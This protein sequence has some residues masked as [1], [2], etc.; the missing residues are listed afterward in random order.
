MY[1]GSTRKLLINIAILCAECGLA[2]AQTPLPSA[3]TTTTSGLAN[4]NHIIVLLQENRSFDSYFGELRQYWK[5]NGYPDQSFDG[6]PQFNPTS[7][8][9]PLYKAPP[10]NKGCDP[11]F[12]PPKDCTID[13]AS[14]K[15]ES[16]ELNT[17]CTENTSPSWNESHFDW[18]LSDP[19]GLNAAKENG[20][21][22]TAAHDA[23]A[24]RP[25]YN[26]VA[27]RRAMGY[28]T[29]KDLNFYYFMAS[30]FATS[31]RWFSPVMTRTH[32]NRE[33]FY[34]ATSQGDV[35]PIG[36]D[37][38]D[39]QLLTAKTILQDLQNAGVSWKIYVNPKNSGCSGPPYSPSCLLGLSYIKYFQ[40]G[41]T[42][43]TNYP[44]NIA[45]ISQYFTDAKNGT[46][47]HV[48]VIE[49]ASDAGLD[50]HPS[51]SDSSASN[52]QLGAHYVWSLM[53]ALMTSVSWK[54]SVFI[55][56]FDEG[57][58]L[59][60]H[61]SPRSTVS[62][63]GIKPQDLMTGDVCTTS[64]GPTCD[65]VHTGYRVPLLVVSPFAKKNYVSHTVADY[66]AILR[67]M[68]TRFGLPTL[69]A[70]DAHQMNMTQ[71]FDFSSPPWTAPPPY[72]EQVTSGACYL[73][74][75]P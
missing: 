74:G 72:P 57:G 24:L 63:D 29:D 6:L 20:F 47:P 59:Y 19:T 41:Q 35:Y 52:I 21:V 22:W 8:I 10:F 65:F 60:D 53:N 5:E 51:N 45:P 46:L 14:P 18:D 43:P 69:N 58:G 26:D 31:D 11:A 28:Y 55:L 68:E 49:P 3:T 42:I 30:N 9:S 16:F 4:L 73:N 38:G 25:M 27:G 15:I 2:L 48:A 54:D 66:T 39:S 67:L 34:A 71:F 36:T 70:R 12:P 7:G 33:S 37:S 61:Q 1:L 17:E 32:P 13:S 23:R 44:N 75:L 50:E 64:T 62:P 56:T 40:W